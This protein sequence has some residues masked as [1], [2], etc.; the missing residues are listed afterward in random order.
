MN[1][2]NRDLR[3]NTIVA[4]CRSRPAGAHFRFNRHRAQAGRQTGSPTAIKIDFEEEI[5]ADARA[6]LA[7]EPR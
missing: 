6:A 4:L 7:A 1:C 3:K 2:A 5:N